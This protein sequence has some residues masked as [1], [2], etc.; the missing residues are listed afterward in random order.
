MK[1]DYCPKQDCDGILIPLP[2]IHKKMCCNCCSY[3]TWTLKDGQK[4]YT[5]ENFIGGRDYNSTKDIK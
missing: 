4:S 3:Y 1:I 5:L 2:S